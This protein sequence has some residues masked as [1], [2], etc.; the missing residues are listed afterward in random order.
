MYKIILIVA[1]ICIVISFAKRPRKMKLKNFTQMNREHILL[2]KLNKLISRNK[3]FCK[4]KEKYISKLRMINFKFYEHNNELILKYLVFD[5]AISI[6][7]LV[8][9]SRIIT[10]WYAV[11]TISFAV[12]YLIIFLGI[13]HIESKINKIHSQFPTGL[14]CFLDEY[15][16]HKNIKNAVDSSYGKMPDAV[17]RIFEML[18]REL[19]GEKNPKIAITKF[20]NELS[21]VWGYCF[22]EILIMSLEGA[23]DITDDLITLNSMVSEE[24]TT[25]EEEKSSRFGNKMTFIIIYAF[26]LTGVIINL[27]INNLAGYLYFYTSMGN[28][29]IAVWLIVLIAGIT[30]ISISEKGR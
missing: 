19:S 9:L 18:A 12:F 22:S 28:S 7:L 27:F 2:S 17:G 6:L 20:A 5:A 15:I 1:I 21:Y 24:I 11:I 3:Y 29:L 16:I 25:S 10:M 30:I 4:S 13:S 8:T 26:A 23:G 14:Q